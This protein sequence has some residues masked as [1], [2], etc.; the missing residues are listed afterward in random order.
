MQCLQG[1]PEVAEKHDTEA[2]ASQR[3]YSPQRGYLGQVSIQLHG[4]ILN[5][6]RVYGKEPLE[7]A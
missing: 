3:L 1:L 7:Y 4:Q 6:T 2:I 5:A